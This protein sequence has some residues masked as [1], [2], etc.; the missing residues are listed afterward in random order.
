MGVMWSVHA[1]AELQTSGLRMHW[2]DWTLT[3]VVIA[4][5][6]MFALYTHRF[7]KGVADFMAGGRCAGRYLICNAR[8]QASSGVPSMTGAFEKLLVAGFTLS[9][10]ESILLPGLLFVGATGF[11]LYRYRETRAL[12]LGQF[13]EMRYSR[14]FRL[15]AGAMGF[16]AGICN[17]GIFPAISARFFVFFLGLPMKTAIFGHLVPTYALVAALYLSC[18][19]GLAM[20]G[21]QVTLTVADCVSGLL[22]HLVYLIII[23][24]LLCMMSWPAVNEVLASNPPGY[25]LIDPFDQW[26]APDFNFWFVAIY[27]VLSI[28]N[29]ISW[30]SQHGFNSAARTAHEGR[31]GMILLNWRLYAKSVFLIMLVICAMTFIRHPMYKAQAAPVIDAVSKIDRG[32]SQSVYPIG[33]AEWLNDENVSRD[34]K[35]MLTPIA[36][37]FML[38]IGIKGLFCA[39]LIMGLM[40]DDA[41]HM[42]S[43]GSIFIQD[44]VMPLR[45]ESLPPKKHVRWLRMALAGVAVWAFMF[46]LLFSQKVPILFWWQITQS[47]F[48]AG[49][50]IAIIGGLYWKKGTTAA[51][52]AALGVGSALSGSGILLLYYWGEFVALCVRLGVVGSVGEMPRAFPF[53]FMWVSLAAAAVSVV[54]YAGVSVATSRK[55]FDLNAMLHRDVRARAKRTGRR[56]VIKRVGEFLGFDEDFTFWDRVVTGGLFA[57]ALVWLVISVGGSVWNSAWDWPTSWWLNY[58]KVAGIAIPIVV[59]AGTFVWFGIG[60]AVDIRDFF[61]TLRTTKRNALDDGSVDAEKGVTGMREEAQAKPEG[62]VVSSHDY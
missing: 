25:S 51:A 52:W 4:I 41:G 22:T 27:Y 14:R 50:G 46:S 53:N 60:S 56:S 10:W 1:M 58:W 48:C 7:I 43:W 45:R 54:V 37:S 55:D 20:L 19:L 47:I 42:H 6:A 61:R 38:P 8:S 13:F 2:Q 57:W 12:T 35:Q 62:D 23:V 21:G 39:I 28:Y 18:A 32:H 15:L 3:G 5:V 49:V 29:S 30:Q 33:S 44:V 26:K 17:Y 34:Q 59:A 9:W 11:V 16:I 36:L 24:T 40:A 31:M